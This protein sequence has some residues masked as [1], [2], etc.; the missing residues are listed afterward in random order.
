MSNVILAYPLATPISYQL[1]P[2][3]LQTFIGRNNI[4]SNANRVEVEYDLAESNDELYRRRNIILNSSPHIESASGAIASFNTDMETPLKE[5]KAYFTPIQEGT[6]NPSPTNVKPISGWTGANISTVDAYEF[7]Q[8]GLADLTGE[9][10]SINTRI[11]TDYIPY[12]GSQSFVLDGVF[13]ADDRFRSIYWYDSNK[14]FISSGGS[15][16][17]FP[18]YLWI[19]NHS[20]YV[21]FR[22]VVYKSDSTQNISPNGKRL[23]FP[24]E[25]YPI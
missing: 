10:V 17:D 2:M 24:K 20:N 23:V 12:D 8:G 9:E 11:R 4:W 7:Y 18:Y 25:T 15:S 21:Y 13:D 14:E 16:H 1:T 3:E 19:G 22:V 6:G 5:L